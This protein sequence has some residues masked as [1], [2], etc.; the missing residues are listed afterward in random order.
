MVLNPALPEYWQTLF[1]LDQLKEK[2]NWKK[3]FDKNTSIIS[4]TLAVNPKRLKKSDVLDTSSP[5]DHE[6]KSFYLIWYLEYIMI[7]IYIHTHK[8]S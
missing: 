7:D 8:G 2:S 4:Y 3:L 1:P 6:Y 5:K